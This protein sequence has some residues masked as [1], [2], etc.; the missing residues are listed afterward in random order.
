MERAQPRGLLVIGRANQ[1]CD[2]KRVIIFSDHELCDKRSLI[3]S[4]PAFRR[5]RISPGYNPICSTHIWGRAV[6]T[7]LRADSLRRLHP[8]HGALLPSVHGGHATSLRHPKKHR[9]DERTQHRGDNGSGPLKSTWRGP[10]ER[11]RAVD[12]RRESWHQRLRWLLQAP[13]TF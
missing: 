10:V 11:E 7:R 8:P 6:S 3:G 12:H 2:R 13:I 5:N 4:L 1:S 9:P